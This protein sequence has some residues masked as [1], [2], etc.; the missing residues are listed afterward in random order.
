M[1]VFKP[2]LN[3]AYLTFILSFPF[4]SPLLFELFAVLLDESEVQISNNGVVLSGKYALLHIVYDDFAPSIPFYS[5]TILASYVVACVL[6]VLFAQF[7]KRKRLWQPTFLKTVLTVLFVPILIVAEI[8]LLYIGGQIL[9][10][11]SY[12]SVILGNH[13]PQSGLPFD[14]SFGC[15]AD[16]RIPVYSP[17]FSLINACISYMLSC[18]IADFIKSIKIIRVN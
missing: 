12:P 2:T 16:A 14:L 15:K 5:A 9:H 10:P 4:L 1:F 6:A 8:L 13:C 3:K 11:I 17:I 18:L 7:W